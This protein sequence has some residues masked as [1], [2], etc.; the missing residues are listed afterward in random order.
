MFLENKMPL[1]G[2]K[3]KNVI[4][5]IVFLALVYL[6]GDMAGKNQSLHTKAEVLNQVACGLAK[7]ELE[8][9]LNE[10]EM[11]LLLHAALKENADLRWTA[12]K[13]KLIRDCYPEEK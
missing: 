12:Y 4:I 3:Y 7:A 5:T 1:L 13:K 10:V 6:A 8:K 2:L 11:P 9:S